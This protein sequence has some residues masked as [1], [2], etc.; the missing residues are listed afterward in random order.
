VKNV[1]NTEFLN[2]LARA[3]KKLQDGAY[4]GVRLAAAFVKVEAQ[5]RVPVD[6]GN[7][8]ASAYTEIKKTNGAVGATVGFTASYA[9]AVH[10]KPM[11]HAGEK[12][13]DHWIKGTKFKGKG[14]YWDVQ[15][16]ATNKFLQKAVEENQKELITIIHKAARL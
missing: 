5:K 16:Q 2:N 7:L 6:E 14:K 1:S 15:G 13:K 10:E 11:V 3:L 4:K 12:R 8:K 9:A